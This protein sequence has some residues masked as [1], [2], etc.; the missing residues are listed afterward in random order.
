MNNSQKISFSLPKNDL[1]MLEN[2]RKRM[3]LGRSAFIDMAIRF[4]LNWLNQKE[5]LK[6]YE[7][8]YKKIP[9]KIHELKAIEKA[10][11]EVLTP[12]EVWQ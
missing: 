4:W 2:V 3:G 9:E 6:R 7:D 12:R 10:G 5:L 1:V 11:I 8:G